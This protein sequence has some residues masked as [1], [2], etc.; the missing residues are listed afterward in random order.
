MC[1]FTHSLSVGSDSAQSPELGL[2]LRGGCHLPTVSSSPDQ[3]LSEGRG[4]V[5]G[6]R[7]PVLYSVGSPTTPHV[8]FIRT[9]ES[10]RSPSRPTSDPQSCLSFC[11]FPHAC[12][13]GTLR[14]RQLP[15]G[16]GHC[17]PTGHHM[18]VNVTELKASITTSTTCLHPWAG[19]A[20]PRI[21]GPGF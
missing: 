21:Q 9:Q 10:C 18:T 3:K 5:G 7:P 4:Q 15:P 13:P 11:S 14:P 16:L 17:L 8:S 20:L 12:W 6:E 19:P 2:R 1:P